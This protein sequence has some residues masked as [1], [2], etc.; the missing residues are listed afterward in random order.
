MVTHSNILVQFCTLYCESDHV[1]CICE[2]MWMPYYNLR[3][4]LTLILTHTLLI[5]FMGFSRQE[6]WSGLPF[7]PDHLTCLLKKCVWRSATVRTSHGTTVWFQIG[8]GVCQGCIL[9]PCLF[10][11]HAEYIM[12]NAGL[13]EAHSWNLELWY[14]RRLLRVPWT[15]RKSV[16]N[17]HWKDW[18]WSW[19]SNTLATWWEEL[20]HWKRP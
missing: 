18:W 6:Y 11:L 8:E 16:L 3:S 17:I 7:L 1:L 14:W 12:W 20:T 19:N 5:L 4:L 13:A 9:S 10:N 2:V 15:S